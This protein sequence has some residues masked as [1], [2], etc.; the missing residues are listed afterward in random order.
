MQVRIVIPNTFLEPG[1]D[2]QTGEPCKLKTCFRPIE[3]YGSRIASIA[4]GFTAWSAKGGWIDGSGNLIVEPVTVVECSIADDYVQ[5]NANS[6]QASI[7]PLVRIRDLAR[8]ICRDLS[9]ECVYLA[10]DG[11][12]EFVKEAD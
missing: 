5:A 6:G 3:K 9:Q 8:Q 2:A 7:G 10:I 11:V 12:V 4:G 1:T